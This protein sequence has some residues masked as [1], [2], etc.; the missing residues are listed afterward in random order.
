MDS[1]SRRWRALRE[2]LLA[3]LPQG[4][5]TRVTFLRRIAAAAL[6][7]LAAVL[8]VQPS[9]TTAP[10]E[11]TVFVA[12]RDLAP[13]RPLGPDDVTPRQVPAEHVPNGALTDSSQATGRVLA[14][15][16]RA[17]EPLTD[18]RLVGP[19]LTR[20]TSGD[21]GHVAVPVRLAD[22]DVADLLHQGRRVDVVTTAESTSPDAGAVV[23][24]NVPVL[25]VGPSLDTAGEQGR[26]LVVAV[27]GDRAAQV[28]ADALTHAVTVTLR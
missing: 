11:A 28:A 4:P 10:A 24:E 25:A 22:P 16:T 12:E 26:L 3:H 14:A 1:H 17:G 7:V 18:V 23:A 5:G 27:P 9:A 19:E 15:A 2:R 8:A 21:Q 6:L 20:L 13:G